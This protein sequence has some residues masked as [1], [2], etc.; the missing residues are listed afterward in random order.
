MPDYLKVTESTCSL[1]DYICK[2]KSFEIEKNLKTPFIAQYKTLEF[3][4]L[5]SYQQ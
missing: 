1:R 4:L 2:E 3:K 5:L